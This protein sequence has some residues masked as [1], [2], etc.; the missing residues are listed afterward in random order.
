MLTHKERAVLR[1]ALQFFREELVPYGLD[2]IRPYL[3]GPLEE[4]ITPAEIQQ[5]QEFLR[6]VHV[7]YVAVHVTGPLRIV[8]SLVDSQAD[9]EDALSDPS[10]RVAVVLIPPH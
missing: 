9:F 2:V 7:R 1:A 6:H 10:T 3:D 5:L 4:A 8:S